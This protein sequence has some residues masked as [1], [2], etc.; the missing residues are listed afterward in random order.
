MQRRKPITT[1]ERIMMTLLAMVCCLFP[2][3]TAWAQGGW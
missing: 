1:A 2:R 3:L